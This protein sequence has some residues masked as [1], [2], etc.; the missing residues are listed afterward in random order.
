[1]LCVCISEQ[2]QRKLESIEK[3]EDV[4]SAEQRIRAQ[5]HDLNLERHKRAIEMKV[6]EIHKFEFR[7]PL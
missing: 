5:I 4:S 6:V 2:R 7:F 3:E 1:M